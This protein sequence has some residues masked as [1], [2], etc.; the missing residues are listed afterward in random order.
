MSP[1]IQ[2]LDPCRY[3]NFPYRDKLPAD[4]ERLEARHHHH[5]NVHYM[6]GFHEQ[7]YSLQIS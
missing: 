1:D 6:Y 4:L 7:I 2:P 3:M 5:E